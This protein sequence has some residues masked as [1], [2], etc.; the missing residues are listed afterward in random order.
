MAERKAGRGQL[1]SLDTL[2]PWAD[3]A[4]LK[5]FESLKERKLLQQE[6]LETLNAD[7]RVAALAEGITGDAVP[8]ISR[9][10]FNRQAMRAAILGRRLGDARQI[11]EL[12]APKLED[13]GDHQLTLIVA[14][15]IKTCALEMLNNAGELQADGDT[16]EMLMMTSRAL[17]SAEQAKKINSETRKKIEAELKDTASK[18]LV[19]KAVEAGLSADQVAQIRRDVLGVR[20]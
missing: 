17:A 10:A 19:D 20:M 14:E 7:L 16:A 9:S 8:Q 1:S 13:V 12:L 6:I 5:A 4:K 3:E 15:T 18:K 2:P 11:A